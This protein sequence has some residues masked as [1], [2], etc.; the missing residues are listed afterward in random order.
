MSTGRCKT[1]KHWREDSN[2]YLSGIPRGWGGCELTR[3]V[4]AHTFNNQKTRAHVAFR[5]E[6]YL[7]LAVAPDFGCIQY[8]PKDTANER[9]PV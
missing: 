5:D 7:V 3:T 6:M 4:D 1:C 2:P 9:R 8:E